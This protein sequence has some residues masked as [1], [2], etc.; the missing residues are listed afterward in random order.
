M[1]SRDSARLGEREL[2]IDGLLCS[3]SARSIFVEKLPPSSVKTAFRSRPN[4]SAKS[5]RAARIASTKRPSLERR[6]ARSE[7]ELPSRSA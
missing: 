7:A 1:A 5:A 6:K 2:L 3:L 4:V